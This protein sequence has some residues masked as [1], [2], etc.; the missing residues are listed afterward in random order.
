M[1]G[2]IRIVSVRKGYDP[3]GYTLVA[4]GGAGPLHAAALAR[5]LGIERV[6]IPPAP[7]IL[8][9]L[10]LLVAP[11]RLDLVR[12]RVALLDPLTE[13]E[14]AQGFDELEQ[15]ALRLARSRERPAGPAPARPGLRHALRSDRTSS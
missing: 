3:R 14:L 9:A 7:G 6:L 11:L 4:F 2:A 12:T 5:D 15:Q 13:A 10:G 8:C 1:L